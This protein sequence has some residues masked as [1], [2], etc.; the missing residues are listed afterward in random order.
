MCLLYDSLFVANLFGKH[1][2]QSEHIS[3]HLRLAVIFMNRG[4]KVFAVNATNLIYERTAEQDLNLF[5]SYLS[6]S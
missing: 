6:I 2:G 1:P 5:I 4:M 3:I